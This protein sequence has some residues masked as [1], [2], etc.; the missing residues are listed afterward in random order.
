MEIH[1]AA[2]FHGSNFKETQSFIYT[3]TIPQNADNSSF[4]V[5]H[6]ILMTFRS[7]SD[8]QV[9]APLASFI[10]VTAEVFYVIMTLDLL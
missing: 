6:V 3:L 4:N 2:N 9:Q 10:C 8:S 5:L 1:I 7:N